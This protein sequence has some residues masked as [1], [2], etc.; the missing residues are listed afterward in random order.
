MDTHEIVDVVDS[1]L[2]TIP[3]NKYFGLRILK[4]SELE[5]KLK[6]LIN[7]CST[8]N[9]PKDISQE[10]ISEAINYLENERSW[11]QATLEGINE[12]C[13]THPY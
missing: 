12:P 3:M 2:E 11:L 1:L 5:N 6:F 10:I 4:K 13:F 7:K 8:Q 9:P